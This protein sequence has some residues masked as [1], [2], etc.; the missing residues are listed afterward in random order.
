MIGISFATT[1]I[2]LGVLVAINQMESAV[3]LGLS[4]A[5]KAFAI[6]PISSIL[7][8]AV[9]FTIAVSNVRRPEW[10]KR[11]MLLAT[12]SILDAAIARWFLAFLSPPNHIG[13]PP[14][15]ADVPRAF[16]TCLV[17]TAAIVFDWRSR[18]RPH[19]VYLLGGTALI[20]VK[21]LQVPLS[22]TPLW[23][24]TAGWDIGAG[25]MIRRVS[26]DPEVEGPASCEARPRTRLRASTRPCFKA[27]S[28]S[29]PVV[30]GPGCSAVS[31][32]A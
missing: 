10:H 8:F 30:A 21:V 20:L 4:D 19:A 14:V 26:C 2:I 11:L 29:P 24:S 22:A 7:F 32:S 28:N 27:H 23:H 17:L 9:V 31:T 16:V 5:G 3:A 18:G 1:M 6:V 13:P 15:D 12:I 25:R